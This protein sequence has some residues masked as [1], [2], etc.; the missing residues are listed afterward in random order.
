MNLLSVSMRNAITNRGQF[1][2]T[3]MAVVL[4]V[5]FLTATLIVADS[6]TG[7][8][9]RDVAEANASVA[10]VVEG[11]TIAEGGGAPGEPADRISEGVPTDLLAA[12]RQVDGVASAEG[13]TTGFAKLVADGAAVG[14]GTAADLGVGWI[15][16]PDLNPFRMTE[17][18]TPNGADEVVLLP[19]LAADGGVGV[20]DPVQVLTPLGLIDAT[21]SGLATYGRGESAPLA[22]VVIFDNATAA[23]MLVQDSFARIRVSVGPDANLRTVRAELDAIDPDLVVLDGAEFIAARQTAVVSPFD[24][25]SFFLFAFAAIATAAGATIIFNTLVI[26]IGQRRREFALMRAVG[27]ARRQVFRLVI[28]ESIVIAVAATAIGIGLGMLSARWLRRIMDIAGL[29]FLDGPLVTSPSTI[30]VA[31]IVGLLVTIGSAFGPT[32]R[33]ASASPVEALREAAA[34]PAAVSRRRTVIGLALMAGGVIVT[35]IAGATRNSAL[36]AGMGAMVPGIVLAGPAIV[37]CVAALARPI[38]SRFGGIT[39]S[40]ATTNLS[41]NPR[42]SSSTALGL[43]LGVALVAFF[44]IIASSISA[45]FATA[46]D[47]QV[48]SATVATSASPDVATVDPSLVDRLAAIPGTTAGALAMGDGSVN[49]IDSSVAGIDP[50]VP[51][52]FD[53]AVSAG[54]LDELAN[55]GIAVWSSVEAPVPQLG[56]QISITLSAGEVELPVVAIFD[57][58]LAGFDFP[59]YLIAPEL[60]A[61]LEPGL[62]DWV[63]FANGPDDATNTRLREVIAATPG[64]LFETR[65][66]YVAAAGREVN[67]IRNLIYALLGLTVVIAVLGVANTMALSI[68]ERVREIGLMRAIGTTQSGVRRI[69]RWEAMTLALVGSLSGVILAILCGWA[70]V[71]AAGGTDITTVAF[72]WAV[73]AVLLIVAIGACTASIAVPARVASRIPTLDAIASS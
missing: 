44:A 9:A 15:A 8:A 34:E 45:S 52:L 27:A 18:S 33:A 26:A 39:G 46:L 38:A 21:V 2:M 58:S 43:T 72:P 6:I 37:T 7:T 62:P 67:A 54:S 53:F 13:E 64:A 51:E 25:L 1:A 69:I 73:F 41:R 49:G 12:I 60:L 5:A 11:A 28:V 10:F 57:E 23:D 55:G 65:D 48:R 29:S 16:D 14:S 68:S 3:A 19:K 4:S 63:V 47:S 20:G 50:T 30:V 71:R 70:F 32:W 24:F 17:G 40:V 59:E 35:V 61:E 56:D 36:L 42:R 22:R 31:L 66:S